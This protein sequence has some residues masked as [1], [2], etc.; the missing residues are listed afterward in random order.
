MQRDKSREIHFAPIQ[1]KTA[2][3]FLSLEERT[4]VNYIH[5]YRDNK[6]YMKSSAVI[7]ILR[8][9]KGWWKLSVMLLVVPPFIRDAL[10]NFVAKRR[11]TWFPRK[12]TCSVLP[13]F[14]SQNILL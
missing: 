4:S 9:L 12:D 3:Q 5:Y 2:E 13:G 10:Y 14:T 7:R 11:Y 8:D 1:G 6:L